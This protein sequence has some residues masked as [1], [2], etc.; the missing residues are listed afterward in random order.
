M[1]SVGKCIGQSGDWWLVMGCLTFYQRAPAEKDEPNHPTTNHQSLLTARP[2]RPSAQGLHPFL[3][4]LPF[5]HEKI[6][7][8][9]QREEQ[10]GQEDHD[11]EGALRR[12]DGALE[13]DIVERANR[14]EQRVSETGRSKATYLRPM[15]CP[16]RQ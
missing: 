12:G 1:N 15:T 13:D 6:V 2:F 16:D 4:H 10:R 8:K 7:A 14:A 9:H 5:V 11:E 3:S